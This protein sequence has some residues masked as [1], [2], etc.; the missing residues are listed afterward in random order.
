MKVGL[1]TIAKC[2]HPHWSGQTIST[3]RPLI[4]VNN[5]L[6]FLVVLH[7]VTIQ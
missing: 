4:S 5:M 7:T 6:G 3:S 2:N 1:V